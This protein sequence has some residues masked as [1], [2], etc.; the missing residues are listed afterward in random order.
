MKIMKLS[1]GLLLF[2]VL[3]A[4]AVDSYSQST[5]LSLDMDNVSIENALKTIEAKSEFFFLYSSKM[6]DVNQKIDLLAENQ[7]IDAV[8]DQMLAET[9]IE[10]IVKDRQIVLTTQEMIN[11]FESL[12]P[13]TIT[14]TITDDTG[15]PLP[16]VNIL[17]KGTTTGSI[18]DRDGN[19]SIDVPSAEAVLV[20]SYIGYS[21]NEI[22]V[23]NQ[24]SIDVTLQYDA[25]GLEE[26]IAVGY[27]TRRK[28]DLTGNITRVKTAQTI[29]LPNTNLLQALKGS[30]AGLSVGTPDRPGESPSLRIRGMNSISANNTPLIVLD[31]IIYSGSLNNIS[32]GDVESVDVLKDASAAAVYGSRSA[33]GVLLITTKKGITEKPVFN[34]NASYGMSNPVSM[35]PM[36]NPDQYLQK[37]LD[38]RES[39]GLEADPANIHDYLTITES[40]NLTAGKT[41]DWMDEI[42]QPASAQ[43]YNL[44]VSGRTN[45]TNYFI[46]GSYNATE[47]IVEND[48][49]ERITAR[50]NFSN[51]IT[52]WFTVSLKS[53][54]SNRDYS[55]RAVA[56]TWGLSP[57]SNY[58]VDGADS[59]ELEE[60]P[61]EDPLYRHPYMYLEIDDYDV[62]TDLWGVLSSEIKV[63][64]IDGLKWTLNYSLNQRIRNAYSFTDNRI[65]K[66]QN[67]SAYKQI[68]N[69]FDWTL[70]NI[71]NYYK[72]FNDVHSVD[73]TFLVSREYQQYS[74]TGAFATDFFSQILGYN[75]LQLGVVPSVESNYG[76]QN[77]TALMGRLNYVFNNKYAITGTVRRDGFSGFAEGNKYANFYS[78]AF[79][80]TLSN[81]AFMQGISWL[82]LLKLRL[83]YGENGNQA[84]GMYQTLARM[85]TRQYVFGDGGG[86]ST[87]VYV[88]SMANN[89][90]GWETSKVMNLGLDFSIADNL[91]HGSIDIYNSDTEDL[92]MQRNIP[93]TSGFST[94]WTNIG[95]VNNKGIELSLNST[96][97]KST[98]FT[99][100]VG[101]V[102]DLNRNSIVSLFGADEDGDGIEDDNI[103]NRWFIGEP[104]GVHYG[105]DIDGIHQTDDSEIPAGYVPGDFRIVDYDG[106]GDLT[107]EDRFILGY[108]VP[109]YQFSIVNDFKY[110][111]WSLYVMI[112]SIQGGGNNYYM[113][114]NM[115][116]HN[117]NEPMSS[118]TERF[119]FPYMDYWTPTNPS[120]TASR[121]NYDAP[122]PHPY[123]EDRSFVRIQDVTLSYSLDSKLLNKVNVEG[124]RLYIS[125]KNLYT[126]TKWTGFDPEN[127]TT[128]WSYPMMRTFTFGLDL[129]F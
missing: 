124:L 97:V 59:G 19:Y 26:V 92:L 11:S 73:A 66:T 38:F 90:L 105:Y 111:N 102:F 8:L 31:G 109:N 103:S 35:V 81:E 112:N 119:S 3:Q 110:K 33:N 21:V 118:W 17:I 120:N 49:F 52:D 6:I 70:D 78:G 106:D 128:V 24:T 43:N 51:K 95:E 91:L 50:V 85:S 10:Y 5:E 113:G 72:V 34:F 45:K 129:K 40:N 99:W 77:Q 88:S 4:W 74:Y 15:E 22:A 44:S 93:S 65:A 83:S 1:L 126:F 100:N 30:V 55:G 12:Q 29:D 114:N 32:V 53:S 57:Y 123:L 7:L 76:D 127:A 39:I 42:I 58:Y 104:L 82:N 79:A 27:G 121:I 18:S 46:S 80:W 71:F 60:Y 125:G 16:G 96:P 69:N 23:G 56:N 94:V 13:L 75:S 61:M 37:I 86:T 28:S 115:Y 87:G 68:Y 47:G 89:T 117:P 41:L 62:R 36:L 107:A 84:I 54:F 25:I 108:N 48:D 64:F 101:V 116:S 63:P 20:F 98:D 14:G 2:T 67:G 9:D 122:R